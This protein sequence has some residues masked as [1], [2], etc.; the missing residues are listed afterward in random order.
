M[1]AAMA[2]GGGG[3]GDTG[4]FGASMDMLKQA[5]TDGQ[6]AVNET[7]G[8]ALLEAIREM[9][10]WVDDNLADLGTL[11]QQP[12]LGSSNGAAVMKPYVAEVATDQEGF[13]TMLRE[14]RNSLVD[15]EAGVVGAMNNYKTIEDGI[16]GN[17]RG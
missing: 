17:F 13:L 3:G 6:F 5:A 12:A 9:A 11:G 15:A 7:G 4:K 2:D 10:K 14:F 1:L 16:K 8:K